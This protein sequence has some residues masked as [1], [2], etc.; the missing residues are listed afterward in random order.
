M[1]RRLG[2]L[3][4]LAV[5]LVPA[6]ARAQRGMNR[7]SGP[8]M[9]PF[10]PV[11]NPTQTPEYRLFARNPAAYQQ[12][13]MERMARVNYRQQQQLLK[14]QQAFEKWLKQQKA[15][16][17]KGQPTDPAYDQ[18][19]KMQEQAARNAA[20]VNHGRRPA[21]KSARRAITPEPKATTA[22]K[23]AKPKGP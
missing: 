3:C 18:L 21:K 4:L 7:T 5:A 12:L 13:M 11:Y 16:K 22:T 19:L 14:Q 8:A 10:G 2:L 20:L 15:R 1:L 23:E 6:D 9:T 17:D